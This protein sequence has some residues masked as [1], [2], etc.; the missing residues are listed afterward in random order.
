MFS[1]LFFWKTDDNQMNVSRDYWKKLKKLYNN[2]RTL[3]ER[4]CG[5]TSP[6][7]VLAFKA[8]K[9]EKLWNDVELLLSKLPPYMSTQELMRRDGYF[10]YVPLHIAARAAPLST[11]K[12]ML[13]LAPESIRVQTSYGWLPLHYAA[14]YNNAIAT[15]FLT[16]FYPRGLLVEGNDKDNPIY[17]GSELDR[18]TT[19]VKSMLRGLVTGLCGNTSFAE[20]E[21][22]ISIISKLTFNKYGS[23]RDRAKV[24][25][26]IIYH[27]IQYYEENDDA[28]DVS[29]ML[30]WFY[31]VVSRTIGQPD[32][33]NGVSNKLSKVGRMRDKE[34]KKKKKSNLCRR[35]KSKDHSLR[36]EKDSSMKRE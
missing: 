35:E 16:Y 10:N 25:S 11:I 2:F 32:H 29:E 34:K 23:G 26:Q 27:F 14:S 36:F 6:L 18:N 31:C 20:L 9:D 13:E 4:S 24:L 3:P 33:S 8:L 1:T 17:I 30:L 21:N 5:N 15:E 28:N 7:N 12:R 22:I 19:I